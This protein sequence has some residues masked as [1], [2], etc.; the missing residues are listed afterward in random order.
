MPFSLTLSS[1]F[2]EIVMVVGNPRSQKHQCIVD[3]EVCGQIP[4]S[5]PRDGFQ[6]CHHILM[7]GFDCFELTPQTDRLTFQLIDDALLMDSKEPIHDIPNP[8]PNQL[9]HLD[10][11]RK[12]LLTR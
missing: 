11:P 4:L 6:L 3:R 1:H 10:S 5:I 9:Q 7:L 2:D 12:S 8:Q